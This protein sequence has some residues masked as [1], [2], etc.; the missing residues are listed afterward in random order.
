MRNANIDL[1]LRMCFS[2]Q[3]IHS[4]SLCEDKAGGSDV[5][6]KQKCTF[7][8]NEERNGEKI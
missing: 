5:P 7:C 4:F 1:R 2:P 8:L 3:L 6:E